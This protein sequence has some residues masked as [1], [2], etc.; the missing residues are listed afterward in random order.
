MD[1]IE[2]RAQEYYV[3]AFVDQN[4]NGT[5]DTGGG[6]SFPEGILLDTAGKRSITPTV[7]L[8]LP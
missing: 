8:A 2:P 4:G 1:G 3:V 7:T 6:V 5:P